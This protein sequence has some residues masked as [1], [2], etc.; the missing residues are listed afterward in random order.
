MELL[1][2]FSRSFL[3]LLC[4][5]FSFFLRGSVSVPPA[6]AT[7]LFRMLFLLRLFA[8]ASGPRTFLKH[9]K[10]SCDIVSYG[11]NRYLHNQLL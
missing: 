5:S 11:V 9:R 8:S 3:V 6:A 4:S 7:L 1:L 10:S 2:I